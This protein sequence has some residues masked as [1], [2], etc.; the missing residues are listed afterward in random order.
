MQGFTIATAAA[1]NSRR[2]GVMPPEVRSTAAALQQGQGARPI[3]SWT[4]WTP[5]DRDSA[6]PW[7]DE[8]SSWSVFVSPSSIAMRQPEQVSLEA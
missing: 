6:S 5:A 2:R 1:S 8:T 3:R 4:A 7:V